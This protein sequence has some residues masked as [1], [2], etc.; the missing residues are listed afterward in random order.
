MNQLVK[1]DLIKLAK[2]PPKKIAIILKST[3][4]RPGDLADSEYYSKS[5]LILIAIYY[6]LGSIRNELTRKKY[7]KVIDQFMRFLTNTR[8]INMLEAQGLD[9]IAWRE[10]LEKTGGIAGSSVND[11]LSLFIPNDIST[12]ETKTSAISSFYLFLKKPGMFKNISLI[13]YNPVESLKRVKIDKYERSTKISL[14]DFKT[15]LGGLDKT[16]LSEIRYYI[17]FLGLYS[18]GRRFSEWIN[19]RWRDININ[20][21]PITFHYTKKGGKICTAVIPQ[22]IWLLIKEYASLKWPNKIPEEDYLFSVSGGAP[23]TE[24]AVIQKLK[25]LALKSG[26]D[27][28]T[29]TIH[30]LRHLHAET[31]LNSGFNLEKIRSSLQHENLNTTQVYASKM[32]NESNPLSSSLVETIQ[33]LNK[34]E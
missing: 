21:D 22:R 5:S 30:S 32:Q 17:I 12:I 31:A 20:T 2:L 27:P 4:V 16:S 6:F 28:E 25:L 3:N 7:G 11:D 9:I 24:S 14:K 23:L 26:L 13:N 33:K 10:D 1:L 19:L 8:S 18:I 15:L 29:V 34:S